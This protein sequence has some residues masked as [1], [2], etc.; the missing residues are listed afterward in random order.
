[1]MAGKDVGNVFNSIFSL[2]SKSDDDDDK[3]EVT[4]LI[5]RVIKIHCRLKD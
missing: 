3:K 4:L 5:L 1:M 2:M